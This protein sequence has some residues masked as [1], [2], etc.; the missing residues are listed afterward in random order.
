MKKSFLI[1]FQTKKQKTKK[2]LK[3]QKT[4][5]KLKKQRKNLKNKEKSNATNVYYNIN[6]LCRV[7][8][9]KY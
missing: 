5:K 6:I 4:K 7:P 1:Y 3:K 8:S 9:P 2:K